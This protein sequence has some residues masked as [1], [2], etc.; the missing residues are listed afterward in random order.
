MNL[1]ALRLSF[2]PALLIAATLG[3]ST[4]STRSKTPAGGGTASVEF[5]HPEKYVDIRGSGSYAYQDIAPKLS[6]L[7][8]FIE[9]EAARQLPADRHL[10]L[11]ITNIDE[12]GNVRP[13]GRAVRVARTTEPAYV[14]VEYSLKS[15]ES[16]VRAGTATLSSSSSPS[17]IPTTSSSRMPQ[18][19]DAFRSWLRT[20]GRW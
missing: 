7:Q 18:V 3:C 14:D 10:N 11:R 12:P 6:E 13:G 20:V 1:R 19:E 2:V 5:V 15:G 9:N 16:I 17:G 4:S 8:R